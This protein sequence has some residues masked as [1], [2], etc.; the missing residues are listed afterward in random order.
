[1]LKK[2][3]FAVDFS[4][5]TEKMLECA[6]E[7]VGVGMNQMLLL[8]V[9][10]AKMHVEY[11]EHLSPAYT[12]ME[13]EARR[14]LELLADRVKGDGY[15][16]ETLIKAGSPALT[17]VETAREEDVD[18]IY[19]GAHGKGFFN[20]FLLG[21]V[22]E[23]VLAL[24]D[25]PVMIQQ[26]RAN[27]G[28]GGDFSCANVCGLLLEH[29]LIAN[30]FSE[31][32]EKVRPALNNFVE[33]FCAPVTLLHVQEGKSAFGWGAALK[34]KK[35]K[36]RNEMEILQE[37]ADSMAPSCKSVDV[38]LAEGNPAQWILQVAEDINASLLIIGAFG[39]R[40]TGG[41]L[42]GVAQR[43]IRESERPVLVLKA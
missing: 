40:T 23:K 32:A 24:S 8:H 30:D 13:E 34:A 10:D 16:V 29:I 15:K 27:E 19:L 37:M 3:L 25:R 28:E 4:P 18:F 26:C 14:Q 31:Y 42:G 39:Y 7:L 12:A 9:I 17:I 43:V 20:R 1:M 38:K 41:F 2:V 22:S 35:E 5:F 33:S 6:G 21:S 36:A 11:G